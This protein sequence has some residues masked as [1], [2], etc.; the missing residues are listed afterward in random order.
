MAPLRAS[1]TSVRE[2]NRCD[3]RL[4]RLRGLRGV[5]IDRAA[6]ASSFKLGKDE[7]IRGIWVDRNSALGLVALV[8]RGPELQ[9]LHLADT[10]RRWTMRPTKSARSGEWLEAEFAVSQVGKFKADGT[11]TDRLG[12]Q[13]PLDGTLRVH[14]GRYQIADKPWLIA[15]PTARSD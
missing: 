5:S 15:L 10:Q 3:R 2:R 6:A 9:F 7:T 1:T 12:V 4:R 11:G 14:G 13:L 8:K